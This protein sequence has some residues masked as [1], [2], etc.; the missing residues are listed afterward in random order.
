MRS[1]GFAVR[2]AAFAVLL[3]ASADAATYYVA[4]TGADT[5][6]GTSTT[7]PL[8]TITKGAQLAKA[9]D[10]VSV[11]G[12]V[13]NEIVKI[14]NSGTSAA[15]ITV[16]TYPGESAII[17][18]TGTTVSDLV[19]I[20]GSYVTFSGFEVRN[21]NR[22]GIL[23]WE[24]KFVSIRNNKSHD[25]VKGGIYAGGS[26]FGLSSD[27]TVDG[28]TVYNNVTENTAHASGGG[29]SQTIGIQKTDR[30]KVT[31]NKVYNNDG[32]GIVFVLSDNGLAQKNDVY[33]NFSVEVYLDNARSTTIDSNFVHST[34]NTRYYR[35]GYAAAGI[36]VANESYST[37]N[38]STDNKIT[39]NIVTGNRWGFYYGNY[40]VGGGLKN[41]TIA[42]NTFYGASQEILKI[43]NATHSGSLVQ[44]NVFYQTTGLGASVAGGGVT[45]ARN[46]WYGATAG[47]AAGSGDVIGDP[48]L[49][50]AGGTTASD[51]RLTTFSPAVGV[52]LPLTSVTRDYFGNARVGSIDLGAHQLSGTL[53][54]T[55][56]DTTAPTVPTAVAAHQT[57]NTIT[58]TWQ[59]S[60]DDLGVSVYRIY[61]NGALLSTASGT[62]YVDASISSKG[63]Y[64]YQ[65]TAVDAAGNESALSTVAWPSSGSAAQPP[66]SPT[67]RRVSSG[68]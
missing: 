30:G 47:A 67:R 49:T 58:I 61:R 56:I 6:A 52:A 4:T 33:D 29:W 37:S 34:G 13:Y 55:P 8:R 20:T 23:S 53:A 54:A 66:A 57:G 65:V 5:N 22:I 48:R 1:F 3:T 40:E 46:G 42:N 41:T 9:G 43:D 26:A 31:N 45:Y 59:V 32:E 28:N 44:N 16:Q 62:S 10:T 18:G 64:S 27:V 39:N 12:G 2:F 11:R 50:N 14:G 24:A 60:T 35:N 36:S 51:Y 19:T 17:D 7:A 63:V 15:P 25:N 38:P 68:K 21:S